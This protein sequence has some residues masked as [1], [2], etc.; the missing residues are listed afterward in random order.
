MGYCKIQDVQN[1]LVSDIT[2]GDRN[3]GTPRPGR[4]ILEK[5][6]AT[7]EL[8]REYIEYATQYIDGRLR[9]IYLCPLR[10]I[11]QYCTDVI[12]DVSAGSGV[13]V[14]VPDATV[15]NAGD[16][17]RIKDKVGSEL[18]NVTSIPDDFSNSIILDSVANSYSPDDR[19]MIS[20]LK[21]PDPIKM[22]ATRLAVAMLF[23]RL[24]AAEQSPAVSEYGNAQRKMAA[25]DISAIQK[26]QIMLVGQDFQGDRFIR[27]SLYNT[28]ESPVAD[29]IQFG[30]DGA[31]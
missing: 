10:R 30:Q 9:N 15:F 4:N 17:V 16:I 1:L 28:F 11:K 13:T 14:K 7:P 23:D 12:D 21:H 8:I 27:K 26:G 25:N 18:A 31:N 22:I 6:Q 24:F 2:I 20:I 5:D 29:D 19:A 3:L